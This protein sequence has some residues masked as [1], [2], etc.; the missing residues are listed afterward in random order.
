MKLKRILFYISV[1]LFLLTISISCR[2]EKANWTSDWVIP[3][4]NDSLVISDYVNDSTFAI[5]TDHS[6]QVI[7]KRRL[8]DLNLSKLV[9][10]PDTTI[11]QSFISSLN[12]INVTPGFTFIDQIQE[13][14]FD[15]KDIALK[16]IRVK[17]GKAIVKLENPLPTKGIFT[18]SIPG[19]SKNGVEYSHTEEVAAGT[20]AKPS[21]AKLT[22]DLTGYDI[23]LRGELGNSYN[24]LQSKMKVKTDPQGNTITLTPQDIINYTISFEDVEVD[25]AKGYFGHTTFSDTTKVDLTFFNKIMGGAVNIDDIDLNLTIRNGIKVRAKGLI[26]G[27]ESINQKTPQTVMLTHPYFSNSLY[28]NQTQGAWDN[29]IPSELTFHFDNS[30]GNLKQ[31]LE[32]LGSTYQLQYALEINPDGNASSGNDILYPKSRIGIDIDANFPLRVGIDDLI[33][34]DTFAIDFKNDSKLLK[35]NQGKFILKALNTFPYGVNV[36]LT[37]LD[38]DNKSLGQI[39]SQGQILSASTDN[40]LEKHI[41]TD[42]TVEFYISKD[43]AEKLATT[44]YIMLRATFNSTHINNNIVYSN[45]ALKF[46]LSAHLELKSSL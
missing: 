43:N 37:L 38:E 40:V 20:Q 16:E 2:K 45:A 17:K 1:L 13:H 12:A 21:I 3:L 34:Q 15:L 30:T 7:L 23:D 35:V 28:V 31:F 14:N 6:I 29:L 5:N 46:L 41:A 33:L 32:N 19:A 26:H 22:L 24:L 27:I 39:K 36:E 8:V 4:V 18:I 10:I 25:Y 44:K 42:N 9:K 11:K